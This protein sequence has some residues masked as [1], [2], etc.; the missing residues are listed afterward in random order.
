MWCAFWGCCHERMSLMCKVVTEVWRCGGEL[1][2][3]AGHPL[4]RRG[5]CGAAPGCNSVEGRSGLWFV[6][7][8]SSVGSC[9]G[10]HLL[11]KMRLGLQRGN[12]MQSPEFFFLQG[13]CSKDQNCSWVLWDLKMIKPSKW[14][15]DG[16]G[17]VGCGGTGGEERQNRRGAAGCKRSWITVGRRSFGAL[18]CSPLAPLQLLVSNN[19]NA[20]PCGQAAANSLGYNTCPHPVVE[21]V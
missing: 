19:L 10:E 13:F 7:K 1:A 15:K 14:S 3:E 9:V 17:H 8:G 4:G 20:I 21:G 12:S 16:D 18:P 11:W 5:E 6:S 2:E